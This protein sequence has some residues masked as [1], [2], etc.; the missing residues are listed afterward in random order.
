[1]WVRRQA[2]SP[3]SL[4]PKI[5]NQEGHM[6]NGFDLSLKRRFKPE[7]MRIL[8]VLMICLISNQ[9]WGNPQK[10]EL[11][12]KCKQSV[13][14]LTTK[15]KNCKAKRGTGQ[16]V[17][18]ADADMLTA[19]KSR[20]DELEKLVQIDPEA[21]S[22]NFLSSEERAQFPADA[23]KEMEQD[24]VMEGKLEVMVADNFERG[25]SETHLT[26]VVNGKHYPLHMVETPSTIQSGSKVQIR[27]TKIKER[28]FVPSPKEHKGK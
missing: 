18:K 9:V 27:G 16:F 13:E 19:A 22:Q 12:E 26:L 15:L 25:T 20:L 6:I 8:M 5:F 28:I 21:A 23:Q 10:D 17:K 3:W 2:L 7:L 1:M 4:G 14:T 24:V 11:K